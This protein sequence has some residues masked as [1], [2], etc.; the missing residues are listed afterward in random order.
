MTGPSTLYDSEFYA[1]IHTDAQSSARAILPRLIAMTRPSSVIDVGCGSGAWAQTFLELGIADVWGVDG[2][3]V[4][5]RY[6]R[7]GTFIEHDLCEPLAIGRRFDLATCLEVAEHLPGERASGLVHDLID[8]A[9]VVLFSAAIPGQGGTGHV[10]ERWP[11]YW[12]AQFESL[13]WT[14]W[15]AVRPWIRTDPAVDWWYRQNILVAVAP[16][17]EHLVR[18]MPRLHPSMLPHPVDYLTRTSKVD[19]TLRGASHLVLRA[20]HRRVREALD[21]TGAARHWR[22][23]RHR[24]HQAPSA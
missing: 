3:H 4:P 2:S 7:H 19:P 18:G 5:H 24:R 20:V 12:I 22:H 11:E 21:Q 14:C 16:E 8:L 17:R 1:A 23:R 13:G 9:P 10:N 6:R 15:D